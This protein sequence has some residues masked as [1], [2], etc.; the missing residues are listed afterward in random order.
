[1]TRPALSAL[2]EDHP[3]PWRAE[4]SPRWQDGWRVVDGRGGVVGLA[5]SHEAAELLVWALD[6]PKETA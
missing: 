3:R 5:L 6:A 2:L 4:P 1:M